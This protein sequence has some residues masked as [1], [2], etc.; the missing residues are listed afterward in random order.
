MELMEVMSVRFINKK[1]HLLIKMGLWMTSCK[2]FLLTFFYTFLNQ[3]Y[4]TYSQNPF[5][6]II[7]RDTNQSTNVIE[8]FEISVSNK[9]I[10]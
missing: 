5:E 4:N 9:L 8:S 3:F 10:L 6:H 7:N 2:Y 1:E